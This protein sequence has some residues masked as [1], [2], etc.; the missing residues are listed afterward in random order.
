MTNPMAGDSYR[1][2][3]RPE[4]TY[5]IERAVD[6]VARELVMDPAEIRYKNFIPPQAFPFRTA[7]GIT[8]DS[9]NYPAN[10]SRA[11]ERIGYQE[12]RRRQEALRQQG[13]SL[14]HSAPG[15]ATEG[16]EGLASNTAGQE[17]QVV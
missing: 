7:A 1:G 5:L 17:G 4:A 3:G 2:A 10:L 9:G 14:W 8:Y 15:H 12:Q 13:R 6:L 16:R 11:L